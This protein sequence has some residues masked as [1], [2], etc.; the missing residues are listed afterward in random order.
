MEIKC[1]TVNP[2]AENCYL[3]WDEA[4][5][6]V[7]IDPGF[8]EEHE[9]N[10]LSNFVAN[11]KIQIEEIWLTHAHIDHIFGCQEMYNLFGLLPRMHPKEATIY[12]SANVIS[13]VYGLKNFDYPSPG[14][15]LKEGQS[16]NI[17]NQSFEILFT[18]GHSPGSVSFYSKAHGF[19]ISGDV[20]FEGSIGRTDLPGA[21]F[22]TLIQSIKNQL[23]KLPHE[24]KVLSGHGGQTTIGQ[25]KLTNPFL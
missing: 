17:G 3:I 18:P 4:G 5:T 6:G 14:N 7:I 19:I 10:K 25:E 24:T 8:Y 9:V 15:W 1:F 2:F 16:L 12:H 22:S 23:L 20:L 21:D 13:G 11:N